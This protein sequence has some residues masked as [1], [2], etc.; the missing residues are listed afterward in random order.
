MSK[1]ALMIAHPGPH[2]ISDVDDD[3]L[4]DLVCT[5]GVPVIIKQNPPNDDE[6]CHAVLARKD[7]RIACVG[8]FDRDMHITDSARHKKCAG[9]VKHWDAKDGLC[10]VQC[11]ETGH[12]I[13]EVAANCCRVVVREGEGELL[14]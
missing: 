3:L 6:P 10:R 13:E 2:E 4:G 1:D 12:D 11:K 14:T 7:V 8:C 9:F 5:H